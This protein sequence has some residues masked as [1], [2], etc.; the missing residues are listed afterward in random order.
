MAAR[1]PWYQMEATIAHHLPHLRPAQ[2]RGL[3]LWGYGTILAQSACETAVLTALL[4]WGAWDSLRQ[5]L[6]EWLYDGADKAA[7]CRTQLDVSLCFAPLLRWLLS[8][9]QGDTLAFAVDAT[10]HG[11]KVIALVVSVCIAAPPS[12]W[13]GTSS[14]PTNKAPGWGRSC[15]CCA[16]C[17]RRCPLT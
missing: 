10:A 6:R 13:P 7:P 8:W 3:A 5:R 15:A 4:T 2:Q 9:W 1:E 14:P 11:D 12:L 17:V 16:S